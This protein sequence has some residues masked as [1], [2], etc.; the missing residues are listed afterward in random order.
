MFLIPELVN[1]SLAWYSQ[2]DSDDKRLEDEPD[3][4]R[5]KKIGHMLRAVQTDGTA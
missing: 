1:H 5:L 4:T 3:T 2:R